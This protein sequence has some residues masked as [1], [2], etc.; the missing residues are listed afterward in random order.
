MINAQAARRMLDRG[1]LD[2]D[3][4]RETMSDILED[5]RRANE[6]IQGVRGLMR[7]SRF[8]MTE[9][10]LCQVIRDMANLVGSDAIIRNIS[11][12]LH[13]DPGS[14]CVKGDRVQL[15]QVVLN[16][17]VNGMEA[18]GRDEAERVVH[19]TCRQT[20]GQ[21]VCVTVRD[22]GVGLAAGAEKRVFD[23]FYTTKSNGMGMGLSIAQSIVETHGGSIAARNA[24]GR[25]TVVEFRLPV[26]DAAGIRSVL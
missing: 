9:V 25:G 18:I 26:G 10:D 15:Q 11:I 2:C 19:V 21:E 6:V 24:D 12:A 3:E 17:L 13:L 4:L 8:E 5:A 14:T 1:L 22:S 20:P 23:P 7:R 16:L